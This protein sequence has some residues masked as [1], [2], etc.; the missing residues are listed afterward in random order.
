MTHVR[1]LD[2]LKATFAGYN[3]DRVALLAA[4]LAFYATFALAPLLIIVIE[5]GAGL[6]GGTGHHQQVQTAILARLEPAIGKDGAQAVAAIVQSTFNRQGQS[7]FAHVTAWI[8][9]VVAATGFFG[10]IQSA[11]DGIW[12][13]SEKSGVVGTIVLRAKSFAVIAAASIVLVLMAVVSTWL[14]SVGAHDIGFATSLVFMVIIGTGLFAVLYKWLPRTK[15]RWPDVL[16]GS[17]VTAVFTVA[18]QYAIGMYLSHGSTASVYGAAGS[19][20]AILLWLYYSSTIFLIG[21]ELI[22]AYADQTRE[23]LLPAA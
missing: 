9:F 8:L 10:S 13:T 2:V 22:K 5:I 14:D 20:A 3:D 19:F 17:F 21:A 1:G 4:A 18:G 12:H 23:P 7:V 11:L 16:G 15:I 6:L